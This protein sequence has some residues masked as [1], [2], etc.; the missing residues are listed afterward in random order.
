MNNGKNMVRESISKMKNG[1]AAGS[2]VYIYTHIYIYMYVYIYIYIYIYI[3]LRFGCPMANFEA[4]SRGQLSSPDVNLSVFSVPKV[5]GS[6][7]TRL[8]P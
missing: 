2:S 8:G 5:N 1:K 7:I 3:D 4:L 6:L